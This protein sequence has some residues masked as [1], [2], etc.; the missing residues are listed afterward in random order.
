VKRL[1]T[2][3]LLL[4]AACETTT[5]PNA[6]V[7]LLRDREFAK[8]SAARGSCSSTRTIRIEESIRWTTA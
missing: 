5:P 8:Q 7:L 6:D 1:A 4:L 2:I 3:V